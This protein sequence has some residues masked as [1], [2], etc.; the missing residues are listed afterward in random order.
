MSAKSRRSL[1]LRTLKKQCKEVA[2]KEQERALIL[3]SPSPEATLASAILCRSLQR[4]QK[5][6]H[7]SFCDV[8]VDTSSIATLRNTYPNHQMFIVGSLV[9][10]KKKLSKKG[11]HPL[12]IG[13]ETTSSS[14]VPCIGDFSSVSP[15]AYTYSREHLSANDLE[16]QTAAAGVLIEDN[17]KE[18]RSKASIETVEL[19]EEKG[20]LSGRKGAKLFGASFLPLNEILQYSI[21]PYLQGISGNSQSCEKILDD[22]DIPLTKR[23]SSLTEL[24]KEESKR[25]NEQ[26]VQNDLRFNNPTIHSAFGEDYVFPHESESSPLR[27]L[28]AM[29]SLGDTAWARHELGFSTGVW[30]GD[31][32]RM[33]E[34]LV[35]NHKTHCEAVIS[36]MKR[37]KDIL[38]IVESDNTL[39]LTHE[40]PLTKDIAN[41]V[42]A[43]ISRIAY[44]IGI[45]DTGKYLVLHSDTCVSVSWNQKQIDVMTVVM[46]FIEA[47]FNVAST[48]SHSIEVERTSRD[49]YEKILSYLDSLELKSAR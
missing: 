28:S 11:G 15:S 9:Y 41:Q 30:I 40:S 35:L 13:S 27:F 12:L 1:S 44:E 42:L 45:A 46:K 8:V 34:D 43:D 17:P 21:H 47:G 3:S 24:S 36:G 32:S 4:V 23:G 22:A 18:H 33:M 20:L 5:L 2:L 25:L 39:Y 19:A 29:R 38:E 37:V 31:R 26:L 16:L 6:Y 14:D 10:G 48:S 7:V 49:D